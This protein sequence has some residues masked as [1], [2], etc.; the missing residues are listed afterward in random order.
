MYKR[1][2]FDRSKQRACSCGRAVYIYIYIYI[3]IYIYIYIF[4]AQP[5]S[6]LRCGIPGSCEPFGSPSSRLPP[7]AC[8]PG[9]VRGP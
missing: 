5:T 6:H 2:W 7:L 9:S 3:I 4:V 1:R 8:I